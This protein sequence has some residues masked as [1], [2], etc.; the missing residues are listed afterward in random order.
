MQLI[1]Q[2]L[3]SPFLA[4]SSAYDSG[5]FTGQLFASLL[6]LAGVLKCWTISRRPT[7]NTKC[8]LALMFALLP[9]LVSSLASSFTPTFSSSAARAIFYIGL[10]FA[11]V[12]FVIVALVLAIVGLVE[13]SNQRDVYEQGRAQAIWAFVF[14]AF[15]GLLFV[16]GAVAG[17]MRARDHVATI[18]G[19][20]GKPGQI[21]TFEDLNFRFR[22][23]ERP[24]VTFAGAKLNKDAKATFMRRGPEVYFM[25]IAEKIGTGQE[26]SAEQLAEFGKAHLD[27]ASES[28]KVVSQRPV[29]FNGM[30]GLL[31]ETE[32]SLHGM[33]L[34]YQHW[35]MVTNGFAYQL[36]GY[37]RERDREQVASELNPLF[38]RF[39]LLDSGRVAYPS[40]NGYRTNFVSTFYHYSV[41]VAGSPWH[42]YSNMQKD[43]PQAEFGASRGDSCFVVVPVALAG[44][45]P[46]LDNLT[47]GLLAI[48][49]V[50]YPDDFLKNRRDY[51]TNGLEGVQYEYEHDVNKVHYHYRFGILRDA[52][53]AFLVAAWTSRKDSD[54]RAILDDAFARVRFSPTPLQLLST[55]RDYTTREL[56]TQAFVL[57][58]AALF[59]YN[60]GDFEQ[61]LPL[62]RAASRANP[63]E[64]LYA[65]N[66]F[67]TWSHLDRPR[68]ALACMDSLPPATLQSP[69]ARAWQAYFQAEASLTDQAITNYAAIF[70]GGYRDDAQL[71]RYVRLLNS[72]HR[73]AESLSTIASY[74]KKEDSIPVRLL[75]AETCRLQGDL[76][77]ALKL[78]KQLHDKSPFNPQIS[79]DL[80][81]ASIAAQSYS[82]ALEVAADMTARN[83]SSAY[84]FYLKGR[85][86]LGLKWYRE[87]RVS[88]EAAS[89]L[90]PADKNIASYLDLVNGMMGEG[91]NSAVRDPID[92][93][94]L[95]A[96]LA[97]TSAESVPADYAT[98][99]GAFYHRRALALLWQPGRE[100]KSTEYIHAQMLDSSGVAAFS[101]VQ[102][103]F[104]P[105]SEQLYVN[106]VRVLDHDGKTVSK[107]NLANY[108]VLDERHDDMATHRK[109]LNIPIPG[110]QPGS[111][112]I[113]TITHREL[114]RLF[115]FPFLE[116]SFSA[117]FPVRQSVVF[118]TGNARALKF[119]S[120]PARE[121]EKL[122]EGL[123]WRWNDPLVARYEPLQPPWETF[124]PTLW[125]A[126]SSN[127][128][129][130]VAGEYLGSIADRLVLD[131]ALTNQVRELIAQAPTPEAKT[132]AIAAF[133][134]TNCTY[135]AIEFGR[136][137]RVPNSPA[138]IARNKYGDC[139]DHS[140]LLQQM[141]TAAG[142]P[143]S[144]ALVASTGPVQPD[145]PSLDQF[146]HMIVYAS[147]GHGLFIDATDKG[148][149]PLSG[150][151][152]GLVGR[153]ALILDAKNPHFAKIPG[154]AGEV[155]GVDLETHLR[156]VDQENLVVR[157]TFTA[158]GVPAAYLRNFFQS[159]SAASR[160]TLFQRNMELADAELTE[161]TAEP[162]ENPAL[163]LK[164][165][166]AYTLKK[167]FHRSSG[168]LSG[169]ARAAI[170]R[171]YLAATPVDNRLTPFEIRVPLYL[172]SKVIIDVP[173]GFAPELPANSEPHLDPRF[174]ACSSSWK[175]DGRT[176]V[177]EFECHEIAGQFKAADYADYRETMSRSL[178]LLEKELVFNDVQRASK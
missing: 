5:V 30:K 94:P 82:D 114:G 122:S 19:A 101:T 29:S 36:I 126:E 51:G 54:A 27:S 57:N 60:A 41:G 75:E 153:D 120:A 80:A 150:S 31:V 170:E 15:I 23:P 88:F 149:D 92:P 156:V 85:S 145:L 83:R 6:L 127:K 12:A 9:F 98:N 40:G 144:L 146:N 3:S 50:N 65:M 18:A 68:D 21:L 81:E 174:A 20:G 58:Q 112:L 13:M 132:A 154:P 155:C 139:K 178:S 69:K 77:G 59:S 74:Q 96:A 66:A 17:V 125:I 45:K 148:S 166:F 161:L 172:K 131:S 177:A 78:L 35:Y 108:Y 22:S 44:E 62:F 121:P 43:F 147:A 103:R 100:S 49:N 73:Y 84:A 102:R 129:S 107:G 10:A 34:F 173:E 151:P 133:V 11:L 39:E 110:L 175:L 109:V 42:P 140:V 70:A 32:A 7:T 171:A 99:Y 124:A 72:E 136:R 25:I 46:A 64:K 142:V 160:K 138:E 67:L 165:E 93:V 47:A 63:A 52:E 89:K 117:P 8:A 97:K 141:L 169:V 167:Q 33:S 14:V 76:P 168:H 163:P 4:V 1:V 162:L 116:H 128:W 164:V 26:L 111:Q 95:P 106:E 143:A 176:L 56:K 152:V 71:A 53:N 118:L 87:A 105:L 113:V 158:R 119:Q 134:Q 104:D 37:G 137:A 24:W 159:I 2:N 123:C 157:E 115:E 61:A 16:C 130:A 79:A 55:K 135:K 28:S 91:N 48:M 38:R 86:E 90:A